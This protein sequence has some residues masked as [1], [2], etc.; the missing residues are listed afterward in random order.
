MLNVYHHYFVMDSM[1]YYVQT[2][3]DKMRHQLQWCIT[4]LNKALGIKVGSVLKNSGNSL[5]NGHC[6]FSFGLKEAEI[7]GFKD[8]RGQN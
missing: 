2:W 6:N 8:G 4:P 5:F 1:D 7:N 3:Q